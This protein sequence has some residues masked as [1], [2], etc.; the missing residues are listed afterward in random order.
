[1]MAKS[2]KI[3]I[4]DY[5]FPD[6]EPE[7][8]VLEPNGIQLVVAP[9]GSEETLTALASDVDG[10][11]TC[12]AKVT[13]KVIE[14]ALNLKVIARYGVGVDNIAVNKATELG[15]AVTYVPDYCV[16]EVADH[17]FSF[18]LAWNRQ[19]IN[20]DY[21]TK[22]KGWGSVDLNLPMNRL[23][24]STIGVIGFG[25]I[26]RNVSEKAKAFGMQVL[27]SDPFVTDDSV[28]NNIH[29]VPIK[30]LLERN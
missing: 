24:G 13:D 2:M 20:F 15:I 9:D 6:L 7:K 8:K 19:V 30:D 25:R 26:G 5:V 17:V 21:N 1:M 29:V 3:L 11:L 18:L 10:I 23:R 4:T 22:M 28:D 16:D 12:F 27:V 14:N